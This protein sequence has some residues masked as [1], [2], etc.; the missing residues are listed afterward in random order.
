M[1]NKKNLNV[2][3]VEIELNNEIKEYLKD[4]VNILNENACELNSVNIQ[5]IDIVIVSNTKRI[6]ESLA[7]IDFC[8]MR[9]KE[10]ICILDDNKYSFLVEI[11]IKDGAKYI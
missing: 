4:K 7:F 10:I 8:N 2:Y 11:L 6:K 9:G 5:K 1:K 3:I